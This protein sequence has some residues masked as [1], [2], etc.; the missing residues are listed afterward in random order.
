EV[1]L[2]L[3]A[4]AVVY[5]V[6]LFDIMGMTRTIIARTYES[7]LFVCL[8]GA[9]YLVITIVLTRV[10]RLIERCLRVDATQ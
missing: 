9:L 4:S 10:V 6:T 1:I 3:K 7:M 2:M 8:A 5:T